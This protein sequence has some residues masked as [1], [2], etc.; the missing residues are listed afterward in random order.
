[1]KPDDMMRGE[2]HRQAAAMES[3]QARV[4]IVDDDRGG[5]MA[6]ESAL[7]GLG[8][9]IVTASSGEEA[10][11]HVLEQDFAAI[12]M[13]VRMPGVDG[14]TAA[15]MIRERNRSRNTPI[16][17]LTAAHE[18]MASMFRGYEAGAVDFMMKPVIPE[19]VRSKLAVFVG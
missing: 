5:L 6:L 19:V 10:L 17:F 18:D 12:L 14:F 1:M 2:E 9:R 15:R 8:A 11:R 3:Q 13:D 16:I 7:Q 4:L